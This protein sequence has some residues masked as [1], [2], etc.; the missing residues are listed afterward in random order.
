MLD[1]NFRVHA[2]QEARACLRLVEKL[3][4]DQ[5]EFW[6]NL[7]GAVANGVL[8]SIPGEVISAAMSMDAATEKQRAAVR[9]HVK[10]ALRAG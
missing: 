8:A 4:V 10:E 1:P 9:K 6:A 7:L 2:F 5:P 3:E